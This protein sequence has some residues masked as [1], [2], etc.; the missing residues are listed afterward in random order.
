ME[1]TIAGPANCAAAVPGIT[2]IPAPLTAPMPSVVRWTAA[3]E[4]RSVPDS[5]STRRS[6][7]R[8]LVNRL[9]RS[10][11]G[12]GSWVGWR[13]GD[14]GLRTVDRGGVDRTAWGVEKAYAPRSLHTPRTTVHA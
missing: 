7:I 3:S 11:E 4:R 8:L 10:P 9:M 13:V 12:L 2:K 1:N 14:S 5:A 6:S